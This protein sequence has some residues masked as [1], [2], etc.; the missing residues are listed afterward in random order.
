MSKRAEEAAWRHD[1]GHNCSQAVACAFAKELG[2]DD[3]MV[4]RAAEGYGAG[5]GG[6]ECTCGAV[7]GAVMVAGMK[8]SVKGGEKLTK[9]S[10]YLLSK[11]I[12]EKFRE[13]NGSVIC[14]ELKGLETGKVLRSCPGCIED[15][16][17]IT[18]EVLGLE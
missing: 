15:A 2:F 17:H 10:T 12:T 11:K 1:H 18:E 4:F 14:K 7:C 16:V 13:K 9:G 5:M 6:M 8:N 3:E